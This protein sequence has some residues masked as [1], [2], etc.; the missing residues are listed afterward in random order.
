MN[1]AVRRFCLGV[2]ILRD[3]YRGARKLYTRHR[4]L[5]MAKGY[6]VNFNDYRTALELEDGKIVEIRTRDGLSLSIRRRNI[7]DAGILAETFLDNCYV[8]GLNSSGA[9]GCC[10]HRRFHWGFCFVCYK[11]SECAEGCSL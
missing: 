6:F 9:S 2:P 1:M 4:A 8:R 11:V 3:F 7:V 10:G 5:K